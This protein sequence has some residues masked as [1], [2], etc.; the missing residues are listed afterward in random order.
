MKQEVEARLLDIDVENFITKLEDQKALKV[1]DWLQIRKCFD[2]LPARKNSWIRLRTNGEETT[3]TIKEIVSDKINGTNESEIIV[4]DFAVTEEILNKLGFVAKSTQENR[5]I[6]Y[7]L[8]GVE[9]D[10]DFWPLI[11]TYAEFEAE[12]EEQIK[13]VCQ[14]LDIKH[15]NLVTMDV[16]S[17]YDH[18]GIDLELL[19]KMMLEENRKSDWHLMKSSTVDY[20]MNLNAEYFN[21]IKSGEKIFEGRL[22]DEKRKD[23]KSGNVIRFFKEPDRNEYFDALILQR[24]EFADFDHM[25]KIINKKDLGFDG[26]TNQEVLDVYHSFYSKEDENLYGVVA[27]KVVLLDK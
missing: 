23:M 6:R 5:R 24:L 2:L 13:R 15:E 8:D 27:F 3:L 25:L 21:L 16:S 1:G 10:I 17:V 4:S 14:K 12:T 19:P 20:S 11:P 7:I 18:Y 26:K 22:N 9:I